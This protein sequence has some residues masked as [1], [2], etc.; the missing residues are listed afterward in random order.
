MC[1]SNTWAFYPSNIGGA[2]MLH[3]LIDLVSFYFMSELRIFQIVKKLPALMLSEF[4]IESK[5]LFATFK[6]KEN[7][8]IL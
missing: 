2:Y 8:K 3:I 5:T 4:T 1:E 7:A 6:W